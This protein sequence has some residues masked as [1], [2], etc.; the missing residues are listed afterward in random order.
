MRAHALRG[1]AWLAVAAFIANACA[2]SPQPSDPIEEQL[3]ARPAPPTDRATIQPS[4]QPSASAAVVAPMPS[5]PPPPE[6]GPRRGAPGSTRGTIACGESRCV[7]G[8]ES[9]IANAVAGKWICV[10][11]SDPLQDGGYRCDD[12]TDC[13]QGETCCMSFASASTLVA[14]TTRNRDCPAEMC[15]EGGARCPAGQT[16]RD[17]LCR[18]A[19]RA[20]CGKQVCSLEKPL[21]I[22][23]KDAKCGDGADAERIETAKADGGAADDTGIYASTKRTDCRTQMC[24]TGALGPDRTFCANQCDLANNQ[25]VCDR[26]T[27]CASVNAAYCSGASCAKCRKPEAERSSGLPP[28]MKFCAM[29]E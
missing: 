23:G 10:P 16:C 11:S 19:S 24:C 8:K 18:V 14:C 28:W 9:C 21:C 4:A 13:P 3:V 7:A 25:I 2:S 20:S 12:G 1:L 15:E 6:I 5:S 29:G 27:D 26:D 22:W 17:G